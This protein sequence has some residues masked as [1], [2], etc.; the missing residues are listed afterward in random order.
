M[1]R[2]KP[3]LIVADVPD[4]SRWFQDVLG[5]RS[6]HG[7]DDYE[8]LLDGDD[9][10]LQLHR[11]DVREHPHQGDPRDPSRG[12]GVLLWFSCTDL[13][14]VL[15][16]VAAGRARILEGPTRNPAAGHWEL[17]LQGPEGHRVVVAGPR[18]GLEPSDAAGA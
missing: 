18:R 9:V 14:A 16:R 11:W 5:V 10:V 8:M 3:M 15:A 12:N 4:A 17:W 13:D 7:G 6:G 1:I 2:A